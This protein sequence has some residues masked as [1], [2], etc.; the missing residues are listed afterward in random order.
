MGTSN[1]LLLQWKNSTLIEQTTRVCTQSIADEFLVVLGYESAQVRSELDSLDVKFIENPIFEKGMLTSIQA[2]VQEISSES[3]GFMVFLGDQP[4]LPLSLLN[5]LIEQFQNDYDAEKDLI[6]LPV[7]NGI[8]RNPVLFS[9][10]FKERMLTLQGE[11]GKVLIESNLNAIV[12]VNVDDENL[13]QDIDTV[14]E[15]H[16]LKP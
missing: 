9:M 11:G 8:R 5:Q 3:N 15:Y 13:F 4:K 10:S 12:E 14:Q 1:K 16:S 6:V 7:C 2:G